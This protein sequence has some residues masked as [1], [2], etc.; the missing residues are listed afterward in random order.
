MRHKTALMTRIEE[1]WGMALEDLLPHLANTQNLGIS[2]IAAE[3]G[4]STSVVNYWVLRFGLT[5]RMVLLRPGEEVEIVTD[6]QR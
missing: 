6:Q 4:V 3:L 1:R 5:R 2:G